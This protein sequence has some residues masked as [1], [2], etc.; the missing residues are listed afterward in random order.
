MENQATQPQRGAVSSSWSSNDHPIAE[1]SRLLLDPSKS[2][3]EDKNI[4]GMIPVVLQSWSKK[5]TIEGAKTVQNILD[6]LEKEEGTILNCGHYTI[7]VDAWAK[8]G[9][10]SSAQL[11]D[12]VVERMKSRG[13]R[14]NRVTYNAWMNAHAIQRD[15]RRVEAILNLM[16]AD[17]PDEINVN[18]YNILISAHGRLGQAEEAEG[19][20]R[21]MLDRYNEDGRVS[22]RPDLMSYNT[23]LDAWS[24]SDQEGSPGRGARAE[25]ILDAIEERQDWLYTP[26]QR[27]YVPAMCAVIRSGEDNVI[28]RVEA[29]RQRAVARGIAQDAYVYST[30]LVAYATIDPK[31][32][33][34]KVDEILE[35]AEGLDDSIEARKGKGSAT[36]VYNTALNLF[37]ESRDPS[38]IPR[39]EELF[40]NMKLKGRA[41]EVSFGTMINLYCSNDG[42]VSSAEKAEKLVHELRESNLKATTYIMNAL[43]NAWVKCGKVRKAKDVLDQIEDSYIASSRQ[44]SELAPTHISY[45][46]LMYGWAK[47][48][49]A[50]K[51]TEVFERM[52]TMYE[53]GNWQAKP[54]RISY[55]TL[56]DSII[57]SNHPEAAERVEN[58]VRNLYDEY[59]KGNTDVKPNTH[60]VTSAIGCWKNSGDR[61]CGERAEAML[62][63]LID[64]YQNDGDKTFLPSEYTF[65]SSKFSFSL[66]IPSECDK[67]SLHRLTQVLLPRCNLSSKRSAPGPN[68]ES[69]E[70]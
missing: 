25:M 54:N 53:S 50:E 17:I 24:K 48:G 34:E 43:I 20:V 46:T 2:I 19:I 65:A 30:L 42:D 35:L 13:I 66:A 27:T 10:S 14:L 41:D 47:S 21:R 68:R 52:R 38:S 36:V 4:T 8:S 33:L 55:V 15:V 26:D 32:A 23:V 31:E 39:A 7:A 56:I 6:R 29:I 11:A 1:L 70:R 12:A 69:S 49:D 63:W 37:K 62:N 45:T 67:E 61:N 5:E 3:T 9:H 58:I 28:E 40:K 51:A 60:M 16:E 57:K 59:K 22:C 44:D 18:D 64:I